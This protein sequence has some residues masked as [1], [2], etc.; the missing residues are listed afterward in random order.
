MMVQ[1]AFFRLSQYWAEQGCLVLPACEFDIPAG[2]LHPDVF[3]LLLEGE[4]CRAAYLQPVRRP[5]DARHGAHPYRLFRHLQFQVF[6][7]ADGTDVRQLYLDSLRA[8]GCTVERHDIRFDDSS[9]GASS[10]GGH[11]SGWH[12]ELDGLG[13]TRL[14][15][16]QELGGQR[17]ERV[18]V[19]IS[20][21][22][23]RLL[24]A[25]GKVQSTF[26]L[27]WVTDGPTYGDLRRS[28]E[29]ELSHYAVEVA[30]VESLA[31]R[32]EDLQSEARA[33]LDA[34][35]PRVAYEQAIQTLR[36]VDLLEARGE[37]TPGERQAKLD[38]VRGIVVAAAADHLGLGGPE[39]EDQA[40]ASENASPGAEAEADAAT[41]DDNA[42][43]EETA[44]AEETDAKK[45]DKAK[46]AKTK[47]AKKTKGSSQDA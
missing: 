26:D 46:S 41:G 37:M 29:V 24:M 13:V 30:N 42:A 39:A 21:G 22:L 35:L 5:L 17:M 43:V 6:L 19:E 7:E 45:T 8:L 36:L 18:P 25:L 27:P 9:W 12:V 10:I 1:D 11:G 33:A 23:E 4:G 40:D 16:L 34:G 14:T 15:F 28:T 3:F 20:Y 47:R 32:L 38:E 44:K 31:R 2:T